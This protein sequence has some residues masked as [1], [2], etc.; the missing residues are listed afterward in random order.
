L[1]GAD[2]FLAHHI[3][4][5]YSQN[6]LYFTY[7]GGPVFALNAGSS[8]PS[9]QSAPSSAPEPGAAARTAG[10]SGLGA[11]SA[12][13]SGFL[14]RGMA[15]VSRGELAQ[16][17]ADLTRACA[18]EPTNSGCHYQRGL[19]YWRSALPE[20]ALADFNTAIQL[21]PN[22]F[23]AYLAR[24]E[25]EL[26]QNPAAAQSDLDAVD[27]FAPE[28]WDTRL[29][30]ARLYAA[31][32]EYAGAVHQYDLWIEYHG[33]DIRLPYALSG[34]CGSEAAANV[35]VDRALEDCNSALHDF[36]RTT[37]VDETAVTISNRGLAYLRE[38]KLDDALADFDAALKLQPE[39]PLARY[40]R[41]VAEIKKGLKAQGEADLAAAQA[42][43]PGLAR[44]LAGIGLTP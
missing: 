4:V 32:G 38:A 29:L 7:N 22:D 12:E 1:L 41:G 30:L 42:H 40:A 15:E 8:A 3:Y 5:A 18:S 24:A 23:E 2:F 17:I 9:T 43:R 36:P 10:A 31:A 33:D 35:D 20:S 44:H 14:R 39:F 19:A 16:A 6:K 34:R 11:P 37:S 25:L 21:Q 26:H 27:R 28:Q 13:E